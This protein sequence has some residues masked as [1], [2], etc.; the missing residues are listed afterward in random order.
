VFGQV[1]NAAIFSVLNLAVL[2]WRVKAENAALA[3]RRA[4]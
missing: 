1:A 2:G 3:P 4:M